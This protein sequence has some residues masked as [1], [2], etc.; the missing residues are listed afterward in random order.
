MTLNIFSVSMMRQFL[1]K[2]KRLQIQTV[3]QASQSEQ[4]KTLISKQ[5]SLITH[6]CAAV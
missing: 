3:I 4:N 5:D 1:D 6:V 2:F